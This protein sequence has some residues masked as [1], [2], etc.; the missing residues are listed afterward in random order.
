MSTP[1]QQRER[2]DVREVWPHEALDFTPW[3]ADNLG[4]LGEELDLR[5]KLVAR[6]TPIGPYFLDILAKETDTGSLVAIENQLEWTDFHHLAQLLVYT[7]GR[8]ARVAIWVATEFLYELAEVLHRL[9]EWTVDGVKFYG[10][11]VEVVQAAEG[12]QPE[13]RFRKVIYPGGWDK[14][15]TLPRGR[16]DEGA[17]MYQKFFEPLIDAVASAGNFQPRPIQRFGHGGRHFRSLHIEGISYAVSFNAPNNAWVTP[18]IEAGDKERT[19]HIFDSLHAR[20]SELQ[21]AI[22]IDPVPE[23]HWYRYDRWNFSSINIRKDGSINDPPEKRDETRRWMLDLLPKL[24]DA[25]EPRVEEIL[26]DADAQD[27]Q[28][29]SSPAAGGEGGVT[30]RRS[31]W[32]TEPLTVPQPIPTPY[33]VWTDGEMGAIRCGYVPHMMEEKWFIFMEENRLL[34]HRSWTGI[35][36]YKA[37]FASVEGGYVFESAVVTGDDTKYRR[38]SDEAESQ[39]LEALIASYL[40]G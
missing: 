31:D 30:A 18:F 21:A 11:K 38:S 24:K 22:S 6:E 3:L 7:A 1:D 29:D 28:L 35:A 9:N 26:A 32:K 14:N 13:A 8:R 40:L 25:F 34:A 16:I 27:Q 17:R 12:S 37:T 20:R 39:T 4:P 23:W 15:E 2:V 19:K 36:I 10:V 33:R 5:L